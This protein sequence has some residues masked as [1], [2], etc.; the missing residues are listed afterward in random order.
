MKHLWREWPKL[1]R[2]LASDN[3]RL[4]LCDFDGTLLPIANT[5]QDVSLDPKTRRLLNTLSHM[6][7]QH[8]AVVSGRPMKELYHFLRLKNVLYAANHGF[9]IKGRGLA[10]PKG[11]KKARM[12]NGVIRVLARKFQ[13]A[14]RSFE[15]GVQVEDKLFTLSLHY[16]HLPKEHKAIFE[17]LIR[18]YKDQYRGRSLVWVRGK[19]VWEVRPS[20]LWGKGEVALHLMRKFPCAVPIAVGDDKADEDMFKMLKAANGITV[21]VGYLKNSQADYYV[22]SPDDVKD[23]LRRLCR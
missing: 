1:E 15:K 19:K 17:E 9:E 16:R 10:M 7:R 6:P 13:N 2:R 5:P 20:A 8:L 18:F 12:Q 22:D 11:A 21:R 4:I 3:E 14:F 23:M